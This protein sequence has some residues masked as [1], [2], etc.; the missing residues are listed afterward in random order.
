MLTIW[1]FHLQYQQPATVYLKAPTLLY[2][3]ILIALRAMRFEATFVLVAGLTAI[4]GWSVL[5]A[6]LV[7]LCD[8]RSIQC[9]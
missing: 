9:L 3:F 2:V 4:V 6:H 5:V 1:S 7:D 8:S